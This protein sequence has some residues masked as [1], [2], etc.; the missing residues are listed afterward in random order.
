M[1]GGPCSVARMNEHT[2][3]LLE[4]RSKVG[5]AILLA[6][7]RNCRFVVT[8]YGTPMGAVVGFKELQKLRKLEEAERGGEK[9][10]EVDEEKRHDELVVS[11]VDRVVLGE[12][13]KPATPEEWEIYLDIQSVKG[14]ARRD[15]ESQ[16]FMAA[17]KEAAMERRAAVARN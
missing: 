1:S 12:E 9:K 3:S 15:P 8:R 17:A 4:L 16:E 14:R 7:T 11:I 10:A 13:V 2:V 5:N 6:T